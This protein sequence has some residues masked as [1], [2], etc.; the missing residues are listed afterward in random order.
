M[1][2]NV[3]PLQVH[4]TARQRSELAHFASA[5]GESSAA[6]VREAVDRHLADLHSKRALALSALAAGRVAPWLLD[7]LTQRE[8]VVLGLAFDA[9]GV[10]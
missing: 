8:R 4:F 1:P 3:R 5:R 10:R 2:E 9:A 6:L 7:S